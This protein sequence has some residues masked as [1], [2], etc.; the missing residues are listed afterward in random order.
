MPQARL[1]KL[2]RPRTEGLLRRERLFARLD[3]ARKRPALWVCAP[4]GA[5]K[6]SLISSYLEARKLPGVW[7]Q[8]D[9]GDADPATF[10]YYLGIAAGEFPGRKGKPLPQFGQAFT[11]E[12]VNFARRYFRELY[13]RLPERAVLVLDNYQEVPER[14]QLHPVLQAGLDE[15]P[16]GLCVIGISRA[17]IPPELA[18]LRVTQQL[19]TVDFEA[20][21]LTVD[22]AAQIAAGHSQLDPAALES[23]HDQTS[24]W[25]AG[26][27]L[28]IER[29]RQTGQINQ[30]TSATNREMVFDYF[31][32]QILNALP[33]ATQAM[34]VRMAYLPRLNAATAEAITGDPDAERL[35]AY[36][37]K[38]N[39]FTD[40]RYGQ[41]TSY[42]FH[43]LFR[44]FLQEQARQRLG[45]AEHR[46]IAHSAAALLQATGQAEDAFPLFAETKAWDS[47]VRLIL[48]EAERLTRHGRRQTL[49]QW[50][51]ALPMDYVENDPWL[52]YWLG[53]CSLG[54]NHDKARE[55]LATAFE[56]F[57]AGEDAEG[58]VCA[59]AAAAESLFTQRQGWSGL[60]QWIDRLASLLL[61]DEA[62]IPEAVRVRS[63][64]TLARCIIYSK[65]WTPQLP[66][67][68]STLRQY[69]ASDLPANE[70]VAAAAVVLAYHAHRGDAAI[71]EDCIRDTTPLVDDAE[72][73]P[74]SRA[75]L[76]FWWIV[77]FTARGDID[78]AL[79]AVE[80]AKQVSDEMGLSPISMEFER[81]GAHALLQRGDFAAARHILEQKVAPFLAS[82]R[83]VASV[84]FHFNMAMCELTDRNLAAA[85]RHMDE[86][87]R[88]SRSYGY[89][90]AEYATL[91]LA[92]HL[93]VAEGRFDE[94]R[95]LLAEL[96]A[97]MTES[98]N[99]WLAQMCDAYD[100]YARLR[101]GEAGAA[102][103]LGD[104]LS[105]LRDRALGWATGDFVLPQI[106][107]AALGHGMALD[108]LPAYIRR[109]RMRC[110]A[111]DLEAWPWP[112]KLRCLGTF[113]LEL[114]GMPL[115]SKRKSQHKILDLLKA[116]VAHGRDGVGA[117][118]L[119]DAL[120][121]DSEGDAA[122]KA[123]QM[124]LHRLRKLLGHDDAFQVQDGKVRIN[125]AACW[126]DAWVFEDKA[127]RAQAALAK[128]DAQFESLAIS[129]LALYAN[130]LL[131]TEKE[132]PWMLA[133]REALRRRWLETVKALGDQRARSQ[134]WSGA[135]E[136]Y[137]RAL[138]ID[139]LAE[140]LYRRLMVALG[141]GGHRAEAAS[142]YARCREQLSAVLGVKPSAETERV[143]RTVV[144]AA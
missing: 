87:L 113:A 131:S 7:Y 115:A 34:L 103:P 118:S 41:E 49:R 124:S 126:V 75:F 128:N 129:A 38:R 42:Q 120:W 57:A 98:G 138:A 11:A 140:E 51:T 85:R 111:P 54:V 31:A 106:F 130:H 36:L 71:C 123:L 16:E 40:R 139:P 143:Y 50:I 9:A 46:K 125:R 68:V 107:A 95:S 25:A 76:L 135:A 78:A 22:E 69:V 3:E 23:L 119:A 101:S 26:L 53:I 102:K 92:A 65:V 18:R 88:L 94:A 141:E 56:R 91:P 122:H 12:P 64:I 5:G 132:Q 80:R 39:L 30:P 133:P 89:R 35:L 66:A 59:A 52:L 134:D 8:L 2:T 110:P 114:D 45:A 97:H 77:Y 43:A 6:T 127:A 142:A 27:V 90:L 1:A 48:R 24:G 63:T 144:T 55:L 137:Q 116:L 47:A 28:M 121:P 99:L 108:W 60:E 104:A 72:V 32:G 37:A 84:F 83:P 20:L 109:R 105:V 117:H 96:R 17:D 44:A 82:A 86:S 62:Q 33:E 79:A 100:A 73:S 67:L 112:V 13:A 61:R 4:P 81:M 70:R 10:F 19:S 136:V 93:Y 21:K 14:S 74:A 29:L 58:Q 15:I